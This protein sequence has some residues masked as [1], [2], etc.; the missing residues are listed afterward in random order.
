[1]VCLNAPGTNE[2]NTRKFHK[3]SVQ[4]FSK[5]WHGGDDVEGLEVVNPSNGVL[6]QALISMAVLLP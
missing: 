2:L 5:T 4:V 3:N 6:S 1:M